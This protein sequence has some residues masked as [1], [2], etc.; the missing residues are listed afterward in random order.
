[1]ITFI[2]NNRSRV[3]K[4]R[5]RLIHGLRMNFNSNA[6]QQTGRRAGAALPAPARKRIVWGKTTNRAMS[7]NCQFSLEHSRII[8]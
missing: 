2:I 6:K 7:R 3:V 5:G 4:P 8:W 1:M